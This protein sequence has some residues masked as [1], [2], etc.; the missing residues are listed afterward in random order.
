MQTDQPRSRELSDVQLPLNGSAK[1]VYEV[2]PGSNRFWFGGRFIS[3][4]WKDLGAQLCVWTM[5]VGGTFVYYTHIINHFT[6]G[7][8]IL[9][10][11]S[12]T[13][14]LVA[15]VILYFLTHWSDPGIIPRSHFLRTPELVQRGKTEITMLLEGNEKNKELAARNK[16]AIADKLIK[17]EESMN[18]EEA[19]ETKQQL[20]QPEPK[21]MTKERAI[22]NALMGTTTAGGNRYIPEDTG[23]GARV[24][25]R[26][27]NIY[28]PPRASHCPECDNCVEVL[29]HHCPFVGNCVGKRNYKYFIGF[30]SM[31]FLLL[32]NFMIQALVT[33]AKDTANKSKQDDQSQQKSSDNDSDFKVLII[34]VFGLPSAMILITLLWFLGFHIWLTCR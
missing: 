10:P 16:A 30:V 15:T 23:K 20:V 22:I 3:G 19:N 34:I 28:R 5:I 31:V 26:T 29:D 11:V 24:F 9:L 32:L 18:D 17:K 1:R 4:P 33:A 12:F 21:I 8:S 7:L 27:C 13:I 2:W 14:N 25:C 6:S